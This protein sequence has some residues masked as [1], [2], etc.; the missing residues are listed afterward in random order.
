MDIEE[1]SPIARPEMLGQ[2]DNGIHLPVVYEGEPFTVR[3]P[4]RN[5]NDNDIRDLGKLRQ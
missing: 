2:N 1:E 3:N 4:Q 5:R